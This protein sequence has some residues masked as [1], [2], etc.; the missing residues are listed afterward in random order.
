MTDEQ[1]RVEVTTFLLAGQETTSLA[2][3]WIWYLL[4]QHPQAQR[5]LEDEW[6]P[7]SADGPPEYSDLGRAC[8]YTR[9]VIDEALRL[10]HAAWGF[11]RQA[12]RDDE[13]GGYPLPA[14][15]DRPSSSRSCSTGCRRCGTS[16]TPSIPER[17]SARAQR[18]SSQV[19]LTCR[20]APD[21]ASASAISSR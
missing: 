16:P 12:L 2:L 1:L 9:M 13:L 5:R 14:R 19:R 15:V 6:T 20:S 4:S 10:Y 11:S 3:T 8:P 18:R 17:F 21:R 7:C